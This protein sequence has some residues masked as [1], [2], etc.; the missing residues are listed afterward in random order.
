[1]TCSKHIA[2][3]RSWR[4]SK[5]SEMEK[6]IAMLFGGATIVLQ[7]AAQSRSKE[8]INEHHNIPEIET[9]PHHF[10]ADR[11]V[12]RPNILGV[13]EACYPLYSGLPD[14]FDLQHLRLRLRDIVRNWNYICPLL[15][16]VQVSRTRGRGGR[17]DRWKVKRYVVVAKTFFLGHNYAKRMVSNAWYAQRTRL[18]PG[19]EQKNLWKS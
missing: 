13:A 14:W 17:S 15:Q 10:M 7:N 18:V 6:R 12:V 11:R 9:A 2:S 5:T 8:T 16:G 1:M 19:V 3:S 4:R